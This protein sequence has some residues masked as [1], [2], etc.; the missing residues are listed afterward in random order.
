MHKR[1][2]WMVCMSRSGAFLHVSPRLASIDMRIIDIIE[3]E[4]NLSP[5][6]LFD[7]IAGLLPAAEFPPINQP[8]ELRRGNA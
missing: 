1:T 6:Q 3:T 2:K 4:E 5:E 8:V 7:A